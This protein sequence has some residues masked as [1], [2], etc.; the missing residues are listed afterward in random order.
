MPFP[1]MNPYYHPST[2]LVPGS[3]HRL[4]AE[5]DN[6]G[7]GAIAN[8][9]GKRSYQIVDFALCSVCNM[10][11]R[12]AVDADMKTGDGSGILS[13][14]PYPIFLKAAEALGTKLE[15]ES[16]LAVAVFFLPLEDRAGQQQLKAL[17]EETV[18]KRGITIIGWREVP[19]DPDALGKL[20]LATR[21]HI[22]HL[23]LKRPEGW[24]TDHFERQLFLFRRT[25]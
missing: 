13:Q 18:T 1:A 5:R 17:A 23:L 14:I 2:P 21:P 12:G 4:S 11:H 15:H 20:A 16:D 24:G 25:I 10:T 6:C 22:E 19:V 3:L 9:H 8:I 7:M